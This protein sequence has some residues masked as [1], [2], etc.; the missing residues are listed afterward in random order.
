MNDPWHRLL[1][2][3]FYKGDK[4]VNFHSV[5]IEPTCSQNHSSPPK[6]LPRIP[7]EEMN[8]YHTLIMQPLAAI[9]I[10]LMFSM[11]L[12]SIPK[13]S[14][15]ANT[16]FRKD[17]PC[18]GVLLY[19][20]VPSGSPDWSSFGEDRR[21]GAVKPLPRVRLYKSHLWPQGK[22]T[23]PISAPAPIATS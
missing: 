23:Q 17:L 9:S 4:R 13:S 22:F 12:S 15:T 3:F 7:L 11:I 21:V 19:P 5:L 16:A 10:R 18:M 8:L 14:I 2:V 20:P 1:R 6:A